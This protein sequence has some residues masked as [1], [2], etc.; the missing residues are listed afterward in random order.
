MRSQIET[1][2]LSDQAGASIARNMRKLFQMQR[3]DY[4]APKTEVLAAVSPALVDRMADRRGE[5]VNQAIG[6]LPGHRYPAFALEFLDRGLGIGADRAGRLQLAVAIFGQRA[7]H[8]CDTA[9]ADGWTGRK[10][11]RCRRADYVQ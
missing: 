8:R 4:L 2:W 6:Q 11:D 7:L 9:R 10:W 1:T 5:F 3:T